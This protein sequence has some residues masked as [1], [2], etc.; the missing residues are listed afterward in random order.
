MEDVRRVAV[1]IVYKVFSEGRKFLLMNRSHGWVGWEFPK[2]GIDEGETDEDAVIREIREESGLV[3]LRINKKI[4][5][6][7]KYDY[8]KNSE[9]A[10]KFSGTVQSVFLVESFDSVVKLEK[11][12]FKDY[13][14]LDG[15]E[16]LKRL[17]W[18]NQ[19][20]AFRLVLKDVD[21]NG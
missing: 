11:D 3:N 4:D 19:R 9:W 15:E 8:P 16:V 14:W 21:S 5:T 17:T 10:G 2:G 6:L 18:D 12:M 7:I 20:D 13:A 1:G